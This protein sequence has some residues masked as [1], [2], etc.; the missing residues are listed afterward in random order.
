[1]A[2]HRID[3]VAYAGTLVVHPKG[4]DDV[5]Q[6]AP[7]D[8]DKNPRPEASMFYVAYF[9]NPAGKTPVGKTAD[10]KSAD[11]KS[12]GKQNRGKNAAVSDQDLSVVGSAGRPVTF[13]FNGGPGSASVWL[14]YGRVWAQ[15]AS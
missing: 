11:G 7:Q 14:H 12:A 1:M 10:G 15:D 13:V 4:W 5:P 3:Y 8:E 9:Q 2:G 6:N